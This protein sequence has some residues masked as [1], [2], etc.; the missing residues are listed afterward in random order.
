MRIIDSLR[1][2]FKERKQK[3][4]DRRLSESKETIEFLLIVALAIVTVVKMLEEN[5]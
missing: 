1:N 5:R 3:R 2:R 4:E